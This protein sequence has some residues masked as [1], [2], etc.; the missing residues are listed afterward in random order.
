MKVLPALTKSGLLLA[1]FT[2]S[3]SAAAFVFS[4]SKI[5]R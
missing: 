4:S 5:E 2:V 1:C 3:L